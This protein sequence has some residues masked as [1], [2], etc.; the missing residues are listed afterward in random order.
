MPR[1]RLPAAVA[2]RTAVSVGVFGGVSDS[3]TSSNPGFSESRK[4]RR[5]GD[6]PGRPPRLL[7]R[8]ALMH[9]SSPG[10]SHCRRR[11]W[12]ATVAGR[13]GRCPR[14]KHGQ[15][16][17][18]YVLCTLDRTQH[19]QVC[20]SCFETGMAAHGRGWP[21][22]T[23]SRRPPHRCLLA[24]RGGLS[25][26]G[27]THNPNPV[28]RECRSVARPPSAIT[29][30]RSTP[31]LRVAAAL[32]LG[33]LVVLGAA[34]CCLVPGGWG[35]APAVTM[36]GI[37]QRQKQRCMLDPAT[38]PLESVESNC[39][40][41][42]WAVLMARASGKPTT[43]GDPP[44]NRR[45]TGRAALPFVSRLLVGRSWSVAVPV[46]RGRQRCQLQ[47]QRIKAD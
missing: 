5:Q 43:A 23:R 12:S 1:R 9:P 33:A 45:S 18:T 40:P 8:H 28:R 11:P 35:R 32:G 15:A 39:V 26:P 21:R 3:R 38:L 37:G 30:M 24:R 42:L 20:H 7:T 36:D 17:Q 27:R 46:A 4:R 34:W 31:A 19:Y 13:P 41:V 6:G 10:S 47:G 25:R 22:C 29:S 44:E 16:R 14:P 2:V